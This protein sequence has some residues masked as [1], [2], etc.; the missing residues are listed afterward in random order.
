MPIREDRARQ[1]LAST[2]SKSCILFPERIASKG[3]IRVIVFYCHY[4]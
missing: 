2:V 3:E 1:F 4:I